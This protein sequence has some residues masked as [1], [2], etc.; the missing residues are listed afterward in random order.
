MELDKTIFKGEESGSFTFPV[1]AG[2]DP[3]IIEVKVI[4]LTTGDQI[5]GVTWYVSFKNQEY[6]I[7][8]GENKLTIPENI[9][10]EIVVRGE[11]YIPG[12]ITSVHYKVE[13]LTSIPSISG[14]QSTTDYEV[15]V[16]FLTVGNQDL[17]I[18]RT[19]LF[20]LFLFAGLLI[21]YLY[22]YLSSS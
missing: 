12:N 16:D 11:P 8:E 20:A 7:G 5:P 21:S 14:E 15:V 3:S 10:G 2:N 1:I 4:Q 17:L 18:T 9:D 13:F 6:K 22:S 19:L